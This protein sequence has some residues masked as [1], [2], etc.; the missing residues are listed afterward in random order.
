MR[1]NILLL[2]AFM[3]LILAGCGLPSGQTEP[4]A[5]P[6]TSGN[7][8]SA[9]PEAKTTS[10]PAPLNQAVALYLPNDNA[11]GFITTTTA[12][13]GTAAHIVALLVD[14]KALPPGCA[15]NDFAVTGGKSCRADM[16]A[17]YGESLGAGT[18][19]EYLRLGSVVNTLLTFYELDEI[20]VTIDGNPP[21]TGHDLYDYPLRF[22]EN[23]TADFGDI[24]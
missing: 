5:T 2:A 1:K 12:T 19:A 13:D 8:A 9:T 4:T 14:G 17:A 3:L 15:L 7:P 16:N 21:E 24:E 18:S 11:D 20:T 6:E 10:P 22:Y 23:Q